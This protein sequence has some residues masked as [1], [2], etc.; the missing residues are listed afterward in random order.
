MNDH[1][2]ALDTTRAI[3]VLNGEPTAVQWVQGLSRVFVPVPVVAELLFGA[4]NSARA[5][6]NE[7]RVIDLVSR[8]TVLDATAATADV[9]ARLRVALR[10]AGRPI[11]QNDLWIASL[12]L[13][14][15]IPLATDDAH[16]SAVP[17][18]QLLP[19]SP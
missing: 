7:Q 5:A 4:M 10:T 18:L 8:T 11:P 15:R 9:Y 6:Y 1:E 3:A 13:Q 14:H 2:A 16:F 19:P 17:G 12:C